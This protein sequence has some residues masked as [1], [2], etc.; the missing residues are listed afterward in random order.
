M[1]LVYVVKICEKNV[2]FATDYVSKKIPP[3]K[4]RVEHFLVALCGAD[5][6]GHRIDIWYMT[7]TA[8]RTENNAPHAWPRVI[9]MSLTHHK[10]SRHSY[11]LLITYK[12]TYVIVPRRYHKHREIFYSN[13]VMFE[14]VYTTRIWEV[15]ESPSYYR[16]DH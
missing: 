9:I 6:L 1:H 11:H 8:Y 2:F 7:D 16:L 3:P 14:G 4:G 13:T 10:L 15:V 5:E 12:S